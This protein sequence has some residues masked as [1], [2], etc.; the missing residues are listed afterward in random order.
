MTLAV[1]PITLRE[2]NAFVESF[3]RHNKPVQG[4]RFAIGALYDGQLVG[5]AI[6]GRPVQYKL[7]DGH[8]AE[9]LRMCTDGEVRR[10]PNGHTVPVC[11]TLYRRC[12]RAWE[13]MGGH[14]LIT[15]TLAD[16]KGSSLKGAGFR[17]VAEVPAA[18]GKGWTNR[19]GREWQPVNGQLKL[20]W[21]AA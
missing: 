5:V 19:P 3:H 14:R 6:V 16:E 12:W 17:V 2:A 15:Y 4:A 18:K 1:V 13:A 10:L 21:E 9:V 7:Q 11:S 8:T 20:R